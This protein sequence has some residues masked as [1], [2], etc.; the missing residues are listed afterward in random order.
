MSPEETAMQTRC[1]GCL[2][3]MPAVAVI[4]L[5]Y[6]AA[7]CSCGYQPHI[8]SWDDY[9]RELALAI[10]ARDKQR[11]ENPRPRAPRQRRPT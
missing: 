8:M 4:D 9:R 3:E 10:A 5:S 11:A 2:H 1:L 6:G 7:R